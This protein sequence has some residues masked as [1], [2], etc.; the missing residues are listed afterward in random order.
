MPW[1][2]TT[3]L[4][5]SPKVSAGSGPPAPGEG[6]L[7]E[8]TLGRVTRQGMTGHP[9]GCCDAPGHGP[10]ARQIVGIYERPPTLCVQRRVAVVLVP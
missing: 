4:G 7:D 9:E 3:S 1:T 5:P 2:A 8:F 6:P 10:T